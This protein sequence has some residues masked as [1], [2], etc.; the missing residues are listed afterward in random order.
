METIIEKMKRGELSIDSLSDYWE[1]L[2]PEVKKQ[3]PISWKI[4]T[5]GFSSQEIKEDI[6]KELKQDI[7]N[8]YEVLILLKNIPRE[9]ELFGKV[10]SW[11]KARVKNVVMDFSL[12]NFFKSG[13][14]FGPSF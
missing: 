4:R 1:F 7:H 5:W 11:A 10:Y 9:S 6:E 13:L 2:T 14:R 12:K 3:I 8:F